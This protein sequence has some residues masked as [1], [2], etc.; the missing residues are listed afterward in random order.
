MSGAVVV[1]VLRS[2]VNSDGLGDSRDARVDDTG[3]RQARDAVRQGCAARVLRPSLQHNGTTRDL[4]FAAAPDA[5]RT[6]GRRPA[7]SCDGPRRPAYSDRVAT[8]AGAAVDRSST[9]GTCMTAAI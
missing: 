4:V 9:A 3:G 7:S 1:G 6:A 5:Q 2:A 8:R